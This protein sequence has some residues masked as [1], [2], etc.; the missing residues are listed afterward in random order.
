MNWNDIAAQF[1]VNDHFVWLN[2]CGTVPAG[3]HCLEAMQEYLQGYAERGTLSKAAAF[4]E[5]QRDIQEI[6]S[7][8]LHCDPDELALIHHTAEGMNFIS[9]GLSLLPGDEIVLLENEYPSNVY[10]WRH[11]AEKGVV[12]RTAPMAGDPEAFLAGFRECVNERTRV[13]A[14]SAVHWCT[15]MPLPLEAVGSL[16]RERNIDLVVDGA[17]GVGMVPL[18]VRAAGISYMAFP[19]WKWLTGPIGLG[20]I[21]VARE[22]LEALRPVFVGTASVVRDREY[23][24]YKDELKPGPE[25]FTISTPN[26]GDWVYFRA[27]LRF[28]RYVGFEAVRER[29]HALARR[30]ADGLTAAG[31]RVLCN[32]FPAHPT[33]I[34]V[35]EREGVPCERLTA[36]LQEHRVVAAERL[37]RLRLSPHIYLSM[38]QMD[39]VA[40][41]LAEVR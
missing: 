8:L 17:Q 21:Y 28:L 6:L 19:A 27:S 14:L 11:W 26:F 4:P 41:W 20:V 16:C 18:D 29:I 24:P 9:H 31:C 15:G 3:R 13:A 32:D 36:A 35:C 1:P 7:G 2:N 22:K 34:V 40:E 30:L 25:R 39:R 5:V 12:L 23:L 38:E 37:G 33:G 10:P